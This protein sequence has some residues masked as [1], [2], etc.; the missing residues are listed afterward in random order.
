MVPVKERRSKI[1]KKRKMLWGDSY[2]VPVS[3]WFP[4]AAEMPKGTVR[5]ELNTRTGD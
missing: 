3:E 4:P 1:L 2:R 5:G